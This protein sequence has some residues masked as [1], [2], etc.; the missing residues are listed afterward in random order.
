MTMYSG[1]CLCGQVRISVRGEP[2]RVGICHCTDCRQ[3]SGSAF[4]FYAIWPVGQ[5]EH[6]GETSEFR[7]QR[8]CGRCGS[9]RIL[10]A[11]GFVFA[12]LATRRWRG[13]PGIATML[14]Y[15]RRVDALT[16]DSPR[17]ARRPLSVA[18]TA[19]DA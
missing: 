3:E 9:R 11:N 15:E 10:E 8:F 6:A 16:L 7:G 18:A 14:Y 4:T 13:M 12:G 5:F 1:S 19:R 17:A 2:L